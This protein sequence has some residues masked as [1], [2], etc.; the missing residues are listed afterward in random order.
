MLGDEVQVQKDRRIDSGA[1]LMI[2]FEDAL[3]LGLP[4]RLGLHQVELEWLRE[5]AR[6][7]RACP[8]ED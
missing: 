1:G 5:R 7:E 6:E 3:D 8:E 4:L 2:S